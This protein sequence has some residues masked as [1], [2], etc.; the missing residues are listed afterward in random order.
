MGKP[1][2][3]SLAGILLLV[4]VG[5]SL[6]LD[7]GSKRATIVVRATNAGVPLGAGLGRVYVHTFGNVADIVEEG[8]LDGS[9]DHHRSHGH[10]W[11]RF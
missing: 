2:Q 6:Q 1:L 11:E 5:V 3:W 10:L 8:D 9:L 4:A 7:W